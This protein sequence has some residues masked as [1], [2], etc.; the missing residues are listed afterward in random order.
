MD[1]PQLK[2]RWSAR[3]ASVFADDPGSSVLTLSNLGMVKRSR[4]LEADVDRPTDH[5][6][7]LWRDIVGGSRELGIPDGDDA[8]VLSLVSHKQ[9]EFSADGCRDARPGQYP[10]YAGH[11]SFKV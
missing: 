2:G 10:I 6:I 11:T 8:C 5:V 7:A 9:I 4:P 1:G 3:Y